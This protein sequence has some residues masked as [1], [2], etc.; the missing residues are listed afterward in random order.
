MADT[1]IE[2]INIGQPGGGNQ[3][4]FTHLTPHVFLELSNVATS[5]TLYAD[6]FANSDVAIYFR[7]E[8]DN[9]TD[10]TG[11]SESWSF[12]NSVNSTEIGSVS[13]TSFTEDSSTSVNESISRNYPP[14]QHYNFP[15]T[16]D[17]IW[18]VKDSVETKSFSDGELQFTDV[19]VS[20]Y[21]IHIDAWGTMKLPSGKEV[22]ALR[23]REQE[24]STTYFFGI[25]IGTD[26]SVTYFFMAKSGESLSILADSEDPPTLGEITGSIGWGNDDVTS[27]EKLKTVPDNFQLSQNYP[28]PFNPAT[29]IEYSINEPSLVSLRVFDILG[30]KISELVNKYQAAGTYR[31]EFDGSNLS[32]GT[33]ILQLKAGNFMDTKKMLLMK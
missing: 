22:E 23:L 2:S 7:F 21:N 5:T 27:V 24:I 11:T 18:S 28:N 20:T 32:S 19:N 4:D 6:S 17:K 30:N 1:L 14:F 9:G 16:F 31:Y 33:Y 15:L 29:K 26:I 3:W 8:F 25:P 12:F 10:M 13:Y